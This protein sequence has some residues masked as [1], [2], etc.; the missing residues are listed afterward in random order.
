MSPYCSTFEYIVEYSKRFS[1]IYLSI[2]L[3][4]NSGNSIKNTIHYNDQCNDFIFKAPEEKLW[5]GK[6][7]GYYIGYKE[8]DT[9]D[10]FLYKTLLTPEPKSDDMFV[11]IGGLKQFTKYAVI[12]QAYNNQG[13]GPESDTVVVMTSEGGQL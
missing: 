1:F 11:Q 9:E 5:N 6:I 2:I 4:K 3:K 13:K 7:L 8:V 10:P 12:V